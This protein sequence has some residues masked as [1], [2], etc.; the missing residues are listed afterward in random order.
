MRQLTPVS[1]TS[2]TAIKAGLFEPD[3]RGSFVIFSTHFA[4]ASFLI[5]KCRQIKKAV[6][7]LLLQC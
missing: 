7:T 5:L 2:S 1:D 3:L 4:I 6:S